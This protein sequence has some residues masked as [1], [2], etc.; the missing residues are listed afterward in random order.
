[1]PENEIVLSE[2]ELTEILIDTDKLQE[3]QIIDTV[4][5]D[6]KTKQV[7]ITYKEVW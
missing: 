1:M 3:H 6:W 5:H 4:H 7:F 2:K